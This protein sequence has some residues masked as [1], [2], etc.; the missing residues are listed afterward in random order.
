MKYVSCMSE[1]FCLRDSQ[2][3]KYLL[4]V[5][6]TGSANLEKY[7][8]YMGYVRNVTDMGREEAADIIQW[9]AEKEAK[10]K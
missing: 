10:K 4:E 5:A 2:Y 7:G 1:L 3:K 6:K 8:K 9:E